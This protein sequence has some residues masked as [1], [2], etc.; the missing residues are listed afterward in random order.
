MAVPSTFAMIWGKPRVVVDFSVGKIQENRVLECL[1]WNAPVR[2]RILRIMGVQRSQASVT[3]ELKITDLRTGKTLAETVPAIKVRPEERS[4]KATIEA[5][6]YPSSFLVA[7]FLGS[8][9][10]ISGENGDFDIGKGDYC[11]EVK[12][13]INGV[14]DKHVWKRNFAVGEVD[15]DLYWLPVR[16]T[17]GI[18]EQR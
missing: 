10:S 15:S 17:Y 3:S 9:V 12:L 2:N 6:A 8:K 7:A 1:L 11:A 4:Q 18:P 13:F 14:R 5:S 16:V